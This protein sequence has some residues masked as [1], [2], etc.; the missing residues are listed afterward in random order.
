M[1]AQIVSTVDRVR[2]II[3]EVTAQPPAC[4]IDTANLARDL[5]LD[6]LDTVELAMALEESF[7]IEL[8]D[9]DFETV[10]TVGALIAVIEART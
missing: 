2:T 7:G 6:S 10:P 1:T 3:A 5:E 4:V 8:D 9:A